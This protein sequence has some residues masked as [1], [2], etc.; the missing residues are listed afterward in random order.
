M[1]TPKDLRPLI[2]ADFMPYR[3]GFS[4]DS[5]MRKELKNNNPDLNDDA[6]DLLLVEMDYESHALHGAKMMMEGLVEKFNPEYRLY[7]QD[8]T[9]KTFRYDLA[10]IQPYK[11][12]R[13]DMV[14]PKYHKHIREYLLDVWKA[15]LV[16]SIETDDAVGIEQFNNPDK[17]T[18]LVSQD[19]D[20]KMIPGWHYDPVKEELYYQTIRDANNFLFWQMLVGDK[21]DNIPGIPQIGEKR[22]NKLMEAL[23]GDTDKIRAAVKEQYA[24]AYGGDW[25]KAYNEVGT[26]LYILRKPEELD[27]GCPLL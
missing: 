2:D 12:N 27:K 6:I 1:K 8:D 15:I 20:L 24:R 19:K 4:A 21:A 18:V 16:R 26:L 23:D 11:G 5:G 13:T 25:E 3:F 7:I 22:A 10:T 14:K 17:T 9:V